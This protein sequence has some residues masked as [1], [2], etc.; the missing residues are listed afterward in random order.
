MVRSRYDCD[1]RAYVASVVDLIQRS[2]FIWALTIVG[3]LGAGLFLYNGLVRSLWTDAPLMPEFDGPFGVAVVV[4]SLIVAMSFAYHQLRMESTRPPQIVNNYYGPV[5]QY[6]A[7]T[8]EP[9]RFE[10]ASALVEPTTVRS[11]R[12][13]NTEPAAVSVVSDVGSTQDTDLDEDS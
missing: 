5:T 1:V 7:G 11:P 9:A 8:A 6:S 3:F 12:Q 10:D 4:V 13:V 2:L